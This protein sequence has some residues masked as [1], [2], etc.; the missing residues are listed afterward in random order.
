MRRIILLVGIVLGV[1][2]LAP[3]TTRVVYDLPSGA[4]GPDIASRVERDTGGWGGQLLKV[5]D[6]PDGRLHCYLA[7][8]ADRP[9]ADLDEMVRRAYT[10][11]WKHRRTRLPLLIQQQRRKVAEA[12]AAIRDWRRRLS[13]M[14]ASGSAVL[15]RWGVNTASPG[16]SR[17]RLIVVF[18]YVGVSKYSGDWIAYRSESTSMPRP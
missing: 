15:E 2:A 8:D 10:A 14:L 4:D 16:S 11:W 13:E 18:R 5:L 6:A 17:R 9:L 12:E 7:D 1:P 3:A